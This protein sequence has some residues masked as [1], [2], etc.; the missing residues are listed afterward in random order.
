MMPPP[1]PPTPALAEIVAN[2]LTTSATYQHV[3]EN[4]EGTGCPDNRV[5]FAPSSLMVAADEADEGVRGSSARIAAIAAVLM[6][7]AHTSVRIDGHVSER[8]QTPRWPPPLALAV[9]HV[10]ALVVKQSL[11]QLGVA[12]SRISTTGWGSAAALAA[13]RSMH[14]NAAAAKAGRGWAELFVVDPDGTE[15]PPRAEYYE[16][17]SVALGD[18]GPISGGEELLASSLPALLTEGVPGAASLPQSLPLPS[19]P[20]P[21][22]QSQMAMLEARRL[23][24]SAQMQGLPAIAAV[25]CGCSL[26]LVVVG[27]LLRRRQRRRKPTLFVVDVEVPAAGPCIRQYIA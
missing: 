6:S 2:A 21:F 11:V 9:S 5:G 20:S 1:A 18:S 13:L 16:V 19:R 7:Q 22:T 8:E 17:A 15:H 12:S 10:R 4:R 25:A 23:H 24:P 26:A 3:V 14:P 27:A